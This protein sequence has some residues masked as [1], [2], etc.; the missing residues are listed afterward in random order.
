MGERSGQRAE[1]ARKIADR[2][3]AVVGIAEIEL[4]D[5]GGRSQSHPRQQALVHELRSTRA[6]DCELHRAACLTELVTERLANSL[7]GNASQDTSDRER[8]DT[9]RVIWFRMARNLCREVGRDNDRG[10]SLI[11]I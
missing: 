3:V 6:A 8:T 2:I 7:Q 5:D 11:H 10:L 4:Q 9:L 1:I